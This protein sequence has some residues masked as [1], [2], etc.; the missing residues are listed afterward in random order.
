M[1]DSSMH[2][3][4]TFSAPCAT[5]ICVRISVYHNTCISIYKLLRKD[6]HIYIHIGICCGFVFY[7]RS[8]CC[9]SR[10]REFSTRVSHI[11][12]Y[13]LYIRVALFF[14]FFLCCCC[15]YTFIDF[16]IRPRVPRPGQQ[17]EC[18]GTASEYK[19]FHLNKRAHDFEGN[20][21]NPLGY[22]NY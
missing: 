9:G 21:K 6:H 8:H 19:L 15:E 18:R 7:S 13:N 11:Y 20:K 1:T 17:R 3:D 10:S 4:S 14:S 16:W 5:F 12:P 2:R 22:I